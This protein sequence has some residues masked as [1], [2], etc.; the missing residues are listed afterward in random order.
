MHAVRQI[1]CCRF[2]AGRNRWRYD[3]VF[4]GW[5]GDLVRFGRGISLRWLRFSAG[6]NFRVRFARV[7]FGA[8]NKW[9]RGAPTKIVVCP[10]RRHQRHFQPGGRPRA[11]WEWVV[12]F[13]IRRAP[14]QIVAQSRRRR[15][16]SRADLRIGTRALHTFHHVASF[17][18]CLCRS[19]TIF[20][21]VSL[22]TVIKPGL[23]ERDGITFQRHTFGHRLPQTHLQRARRII[24]ARR[25]AIHRSL[26]IARR[27]RLCSRRGGRCADQ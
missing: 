1:Q 21:K 8:L 11:A 7:A 25:T 10:P 16:N 12:S 6:G 13:E 18:Q 20:A 19:T 27:H 14:P 15:N 5:R 2:F 26:A 24:I 9:P 23:S 3:T 17:L 22:A 4:L